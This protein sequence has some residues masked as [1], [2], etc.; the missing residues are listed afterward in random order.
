[1]SRSNVD[2]VNVDSPDEMTQDAVGGTS[3]PMSFATDKIVLKIDFNVK[4]GTNPV[5][6]DIA[7]TTISETGDVT[8]V[9]IMLFDDGNY[10]IEKL[11][12]KL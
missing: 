9:E 3:P 12:S 4:E 7:F 11:V 2:V 5:L 1:M 6:S 8:K 10:E